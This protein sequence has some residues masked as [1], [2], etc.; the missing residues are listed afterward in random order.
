MKKVA[1]LCQNRPTQRVAGI[2]YNNCMEFDTY[3]PRNGLMSSKILAPSVVN[4]K[5]EAI[6]SYCE[7]RAS[8][9]S[10]IRGE[11]EDTELNEL[12]ELNMK[13]NERCLLLFASARNLTVTTQTFMTSQ[14]V[15]PHFVDNIIIV[16]P[17][18]L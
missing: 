4:Q 18:L 10:R 6:V 15:D 2:Y 12:N 14:I 5:R 13:P 7:K 3:T 16:T 8:R 1:C 9:I 11:E 17:L